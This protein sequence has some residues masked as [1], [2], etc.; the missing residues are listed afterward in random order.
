MHL[1]S[2]FQRLKERK[3]FQWTVGYLAGAFV[4]LE[5]FDIVADQFGWALWIKQGVTVALLF[6]LAVTL[7]LAWHHGEKGRQEMSVGELVTVVFLLSLAGLSMFALRGRSQNQAGMQ[8]AS[9]SFGFSRNTPHERSVAVLPCTDMSQEGDQAYFADGLADELTTR[10]GAIH[11][12]RVAARTSA[13]SFKDSDEDIVTIAAVLNVRNVLT[14]GVRKDG[15]RVRITANLVDAEEGFERWSDRYDSELGDILAVQ[16]QIALAIAEALEAELAGDERTRLASRETENQEAYDLYLRGIGYQWRQPWS[17]EN[18]SRALDFF[19]AAVEADS[20]FAAAWALLATS[21]VSFGNFHAIAPEEAYSQAEVAA[22]RAVALDNDLAHAHWALGWVKFAYYYD[23]EGGEEEFRRTIA[24]APNDFTGYHSLTFPLAVFGKLEEAKA[25][26]EEAISLDPLALWPRIGL[27]EVRFKMGDW[28]GI[29]A[30]AEASL[31]LEPNDLM[32]LMYLALARAHKGAFA[33]AIPAAL[34]AESLAPE[35]PYFILMAANVFAM[36]GDT[37]AARDRLDRMEAAWQEGAPNVSPG[38]L[39]TVY[40][41]LGDADQTIALLN[42]AADTY[43]S[44]TFS[45]NRPVLRPYWG[46]PRFGALLDRLGLPREAY[47]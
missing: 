47:Q 42:R 44:W 2:L 26:A 14:C 31:A 6:G 38:T 15:D 39:A 41:S 3:L 21:Y 17:R 23:W 29:I 36:A 19:Q 10:I 13:F 7:V 34:K 11:D 30:D 40:A 25:A 12:L 5:A 18:Q 37:S 22:N 16:E 1:P 32:S 43:D 9:M 46:D 24:L 8:T 27:T 20:T 33:E 45:L 4:C 35:E 28:D